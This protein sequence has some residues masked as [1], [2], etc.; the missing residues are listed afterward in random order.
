MLF[1]MLHAPW[2]NTADMW[3]EEEQE[4]ARKGVEILKSFLTLCAELE[5]PMLALRS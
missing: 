5:I 2:G 4:G 3:N 1:N